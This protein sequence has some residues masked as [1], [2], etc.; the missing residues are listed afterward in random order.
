MKFYEVLQ[1]GDDKESR[2]RNHAPS[3]LLFAV[4]KHFGNSKFN[5]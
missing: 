5:I 1:Y 2:I 3:K 4:T